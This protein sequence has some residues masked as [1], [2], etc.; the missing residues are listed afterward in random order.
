MIHADSVAEIR[1]EGKQQN[2]GYRSL[3]AGFSIRPIYTGMNLKYGTIL[4]HKSVIRPVRTGMNRHEQVR[5][6]I[7]RDPPR[8]HGDESDYPCIGYGG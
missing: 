1:E 4:C 6:H 5:S 2:T 7:I 3:L 8:T